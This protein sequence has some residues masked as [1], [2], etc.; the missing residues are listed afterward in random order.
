[1]ALSSIIKKTCPHCGKVA[2]E[3]D[4]IDLGS[5]KLITLECGCVVTED[6]LIITRDIID[7]DSRYKRIGAF[8]PRNYQIEGMKFAEASNVRCLIADDMG[9][10]KTLQ[11]FGVLVLN[12][13]RL[14]PAIYVTKAT[15][16]HQTFHEAGKASENKLLVQVIGSGKERALPGFDLYVMTYDRLKVEGLFDMIGGLSSIKTI[17][18]DECQAI[19]NHLSGRA[20]AAQDVARDIPHVMA[21]SGTPIKNHAG[22]YFTILNILQPT[23]F[24]YHQRF[25]NEW[26]DSYWNGYGNKC[27]GLSDPDKFKEFTKDFIIRRTRKEAAPEIPDIDRQFFHCELNKKLGKAYEA[28]QKELEELYYKD[29]DENTTTAIIAIMTKMR[30]IT[31]LSKV[32]ECFDYVTEFLESN[33]NDEKITIFCHHHDVVTLLKR[34][35]N[36]YLASDDV[37]LNPVL[38][39]NSSLN[40]FE[41]AG[42]V[43]RFRDDIKNRV[44]IASTLA[45]GE[46][47]NLQFC[48]TAVML[49]RQWNPANEEQ[50][51]SRF[52]R[53]GQLANKITVL[54]MI[55]TG[56]IDEYFTELVEQKRAIVASTLDNRELAWDSN[57]LMKELAGILVTRGKDKWKLVA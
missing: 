14:L 40:A 37:K 10:G 8:T 7:P 3:K 55:A 9:L 30:V 32:S 47:L 24:P 52:A 33:T 18:F 53:L 39:L 31:G 50:A 49:E 13:E 22:E 43:E 5:V 11:A 34:E 26:V 21:L 42:L 1:M 35:L 12:R 4:R 44:L 19:K 16:T 46:G 45:A 17:I 51:E 57:S 28:V 38:D 2:Q 29:E 54:Y 25:I 6:T 36:K 20:K 27:G 23:R 48:S 41:R 15:V 56:T